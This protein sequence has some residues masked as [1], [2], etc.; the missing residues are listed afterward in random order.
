MKHQGREEAIKL[1]KREFLETLQTNSG[2]KCKLQKVKKKRRWGPQSLGLLLGGSGVYRREMV[3][4][5][6]A[7]LGPMK[8]SSEKS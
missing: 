8:T 3:Y 5:I 6:E 1:A 2:V 4:W 7:V